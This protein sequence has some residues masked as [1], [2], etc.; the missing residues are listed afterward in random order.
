MFHP[1]INFISY[2]NVRIKSFIIASIYLV[3]VADLGYFDPA[4]KMPTLWVVA[5]LVPI[6]GGVVLA[7]VTEVS[8]NW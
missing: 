4:D 3:F 8:F 5:S 7:S 6:M 2:I 1:I